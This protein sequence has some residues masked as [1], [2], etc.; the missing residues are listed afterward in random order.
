MKILIA[1]THFRPLGDGASHYAVTLAKG[2]QEQGH[3]LWLVSSNPL[4]AELKD[5]LTMPHLILPVDQ[6]QKSFPNAITAIRAIRKL[7]VKE[8]LDVIHSLH[9]WLGVLSWT[10]SRGL[11]TKL[12]SSDLSILTGKQRFTRW[13]DHVISVSFAGKEHLI[14]YFKVD[15]R[16]ITVIHNAIEISP[17]SDL[18]ITHTKTE[19]GLK[20]DDLILLNIGRLDIPKGQKHLL[21]AMPALIARWPQIKLVIVGDGFL[22]PELKYQAKQLGIQD[23]VIF[24]G[25]RKEVASI[26]ALAHLYIHPSLWEGLPFALLEAMMLGVPVIAGNVGG[27]PEVVTHGE[28]GLLVEPGNSRALAEIITLALQDHSLCARLAQA[29]QQ[30]VREKFTVKTMVE[31]TEAVYKKV[32]SG[33]TNNC[34]L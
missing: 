3:Q 10:A 32:C 12:V 28:T 11:P 30:R 4:P 1:V 20:D 26:L 22:G 21:E 6:H 34:P 5:Q 2:L 24:A 19:L 15:P 29:G 9:R 23:H 31:Q 27:I 16:N 18:E 25:F 33:P 8:Q 14:K 13:G 7:A 17:A